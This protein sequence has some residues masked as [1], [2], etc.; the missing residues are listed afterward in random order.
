MPGPVVVQILV[1]LV[2]LFF[3]S[4]SKLLF[5]ASSLKDR[6]EKCMTWAVGLWSSHTL[7]FLKLL[8]QEWSGLQNVNWKENVYLMEQCISLCGK[9]ALTLKEEGGFGGQEMGRN[10]QQKTQAQQC[11]LRLGRHELNSDDT[12]KN[13]ALWSH[14]CPHV[15]SLCV[16]MNTCKHKLTWGVNIVG[17]L[18][19]RLQQRYL[20]KIALWHMAVCV[21][22]YSMYTYTYIWA[23][24]KLGVIQDKENSCEWKIFTIKDHF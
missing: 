16:C 22:V 2:V 6:M 11:S 9:E 3:F 19:Y 10:P 7:Y 13:F 12:L 21:C 18:L 14:K 1:C 8:Y 20:F 24:Q 4:V 23:L 15:Q 17:S 5:K